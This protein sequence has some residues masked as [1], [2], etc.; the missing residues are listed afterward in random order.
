MTH[1]WIRNIVVA[2]VVVVATLVAVALES[3]DP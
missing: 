1:S 2:T 3:S